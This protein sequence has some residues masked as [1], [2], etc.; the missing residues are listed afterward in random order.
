MPLK[1]FVLEM[2]LMRSNAVNKIGPSRGKIP[3][4][5]KTT[6]CNSHWINKQKRSMEIKVKI[7]LPQSC[8]NIQKTKAADHLHGY[9]YCC[10]NIKE[11]PKVLA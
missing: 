2:F 1:E 5:R 4:D 9:K 10:G 8:I 11:N 6:K 7:A 3:I